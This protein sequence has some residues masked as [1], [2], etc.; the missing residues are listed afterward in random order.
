MFEISGRARGEAWRSCEPE[1]IWRS[2]LDRVELAKSRD[3]YWGLSDQKCCFGQNNP[4]SLLACTSLIN[5]E[6]ED[7]SNLRSKTKPNR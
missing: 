6:D 4:F 2:W 5:L 3:E 1:W 7:G